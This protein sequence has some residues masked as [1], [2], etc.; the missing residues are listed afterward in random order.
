MGLRIA[1]AE[2]EGLPRGER[3]PSQMISNRD[4]DLGLATAPD[5]P[6]EIAEVGDFGAADA[7]EAFFR[8]A[9][10]ATRMIRP[11]RNCW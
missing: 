4:F 9:K 11:F 10:T 5:L 3:G 2:V 7:G 6:V 1:L 8:L